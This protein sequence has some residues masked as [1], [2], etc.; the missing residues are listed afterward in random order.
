MLNS[1]EDNEDQAVTLARVM[2]MAA[3][4]M[5]KGGEKVTATMATTTKTATMVTTATTAMIETTVM[6]AMMATMATM[7]TTGK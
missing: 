6:T 5:T 7:A 2:T 3:R 4:A 1:N